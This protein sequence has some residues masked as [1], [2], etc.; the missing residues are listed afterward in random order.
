MSN[1]STDATF[2]VVYITAPAAAGRELAKGLVEAHLAAC[3]QVVSGVTSVYRWQGTVEEEPEA[4]LILKTD[5]HL[6][7]DISNYLDVHHPYDLPECVFVP[8][9][10]GSP[11]YLSWLGESV[12]SGD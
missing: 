12:G 2:G 1:R 5:M 8:I 10:S 6:V 11:G 4:L 7:E 3:V 9:T